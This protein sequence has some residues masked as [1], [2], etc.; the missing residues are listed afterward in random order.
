[1]EGFGGVGRK[2]NIALAAASIS[3]R[4]AALGDVVEI[5]DSRR[6]PLSSDVRARRTGP[7]PYYGANGL[8]GYLDDYLFEG[9]HVLLAE[10]GGYWGPGQQSAY[11]V[12]G[13]FWVNNHAH[14][15]R[16]RD[17]RTDSSYLALVLNFLDLTGFISGTTRGK[18][19][20]GVMKAIEIPLPPLDEQRRIVRILSAIQRAREASHA[21]SVALATTRESLFRMLFTGKD[22]PLVRLGDE[23]TLQRGHDLPSHVRESGEV[24]VISSSGVTG[25]HSAAKAQG[26]GVVIGRYGTLGKVHYVVGPYWPLNTTLYVTDFRDNE[27]RFVRFF[28]ETLAYEDHSDKTSVPGINRNDLHGLVVG[29]PPV[30]TQRR[31]ADVLEAIHRRMD[32]EEKA[33]RA[34]AKVFDAAAASVFGVYA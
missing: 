12:D 31:I 8:V 22:W 17:D 30:A 11:L 33:A 29:W 9:K 19:T 25:F 1:M 4:M 21:V 34:L 27:P 23:I 20:Q 32:A 7:Y 13:K 26:P 10:D 2:L 16:A 28:L 3:S 14:I 24:P 18:L 15:L 6:I 5:L